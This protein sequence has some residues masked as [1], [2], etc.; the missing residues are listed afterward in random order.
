MFDP[1]E[2]RELADEINSRM[3]CE[4]VWLDEIIDEIRNAN[5]R[6]Q[7]RPIR[8]YHATALS[9]MASDGGNHKFY[10]DPFQHQLI[11]VVDNSGHVLARR[12]I[13]LTTDVDELFDR[14]FNDPGTYREPISALGKLVF[15]LSEYQGISIRSLHEL[16]HMIPKSEHASDPDRSSWVLTYRDIW[17]WA[18]VYDQISSRAF[19]SDTIILREGLL[20]TKIFAK[21]NFIALGDLISTHIQRIKR[22]TS[23]DVYLVGVAKSSNVINKYRLALLVENVFPSGN[24]Y[25]V[26]IPRSLELLAYK[27][28][29][30]ARGR[31]TIGLSGE[32]PK[33]VFGSMYLVRFSPS[34]ASIIRAVDIFDDQTQEADKIIGYLSTDAYDSFPIPDFPMSIQR[35]HEAAKLN[36][37]DAD[38]LSSTLTNAIQASLQ[39]AYGSRASDIIDLIN[40]AGDPDSARY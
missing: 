29:E 11:R 24:E 33:F 16:S 17:E 35:A 2:L 6:R 30:F 7:A 37:F 32:E 25:F 4:R 27:Y 8:K 21:R 22:E 18:V 14:E 23:K 20:R 28:P 38:F 5:L 1:E 10:F 26:R 19:A 40:M 9:V 36:D 31:E 34:P 12:S 3:L 39:V 15:D 13:A